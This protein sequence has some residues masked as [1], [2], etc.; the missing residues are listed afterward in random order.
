LTL[1]IQ[2]KAAAYS[3]PYKF[4]SKELDE[5]TGL[6]YF[7]ARYYDAGLSLWYGVDPEYDRAPNWTPFRYAFNNPIR[8][9]DPT[10]KFEIDEATAKK[11][12]EFAKYLKNLKETYAGK[13]KE[14]KEAFKQY[15]ELNDDQ[16]NEMLTY[17]KGPR[18]HVLDLSKQNANGVTSPDGKNIGIN[19][20]IVDDFEVRAMIPNDQFFNKSA[21]VLLES[22]LFHEGTHSGDILSD[23]KMTQTEYEKD[24]SGFTSFLKPVRDGVEGGKNFERKAYGIDINRSS[25]GGYVSRKF[26][27]YLGKFEMKRDNT[28]IRE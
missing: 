4:T 23:G 16:I 7:G 24:N 26:G 13:T 19:E 6:Y 10:G 25:V 14:F 3:T 15:S 5:E 17:G 27:L 2:Q 21:E 22:T 28:L 11:Y 8:I 9:S 1:S 18:V 20:C 12:P